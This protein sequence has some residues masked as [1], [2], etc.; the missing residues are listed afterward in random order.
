M[1][2]TY[3]H[4]EQKD[5]SLLANVIRRAFEEFN[6]PKEGTVYTD[7]TTDHLYDVFQHPKSIYW[8]AEDNDQFLGGCGVY[9][10]NGLPGGCAE[11]VK[12]FLDP[13]ARGKGIGKELM[14]RAIES[15]KQLGYNQIYLE[16]FPELAKAVSIYEKA[17]FKKLDHSMGNSG[18]PCTIWMLKEL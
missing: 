4:L 1:S 17:G 9:P 8:V 11:L 5:N 2:I 6:V 7:P 14:E 16:S 12:F 13:A 10:T 15:A 3:R 18:H